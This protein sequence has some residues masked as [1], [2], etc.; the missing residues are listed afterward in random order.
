MCAGC[1]AFFYSGTFL[2]MKG[3]KGLYE[4]FDYW[5]K[6]GKEGN[7]HAKE[8]YH[9]LKLMARYEWPSCVGLLVALLV[10]FQSL[11]PPMPR[12]IRGLATYGLGALAAYSLIPYKT[13]WCIV[14]LTWPFLLLFGYVID[15]A[16]TKL[17]VYGGLMDVAAAAL[18]AGNLWYTV[19]L[20][21]FHFT[22]AKEPYVYVQ[23]FPD[24][25]KLMK[26]LNELTA[27]NPANFHIIGNIMVESYHPLPWLL[28]EFD[29]IGYCGEERTPEP[30]D[31]DF[32]LVEES[33]VNDVES[34]LK[35]PYFTEKLR[36]R[37]AQDPSKLY[38]NAKTFGWYFP[39]KK[40]DFQ[41]QENV[42]EATPAAK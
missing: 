22:D 30:M 31:A 32:L 5:F 35:E 11:L 16:L 29:R 23:T 8:W 2:D 39:N 1:V 27:R 28:G 10:L 21:F 18:L 15:L 7:G 33:R 4:T 13:P 14:S 26:P 34:A 20:N 38:L 19:E 42:P 9:W 37:D 24:I 17:G 40:P 6:T 25:E 12:F 36:L 3:L 41:P